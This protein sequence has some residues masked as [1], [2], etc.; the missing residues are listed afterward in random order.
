MNNEFE[1][2]VGEE[3]RDRFF[4]C[5]EEI[6]SSKLFD[7]AHGYQGAKMDAARHFLP[8]RPSILGFLSARS[9][10]LIRLQPN[11]SAKQVV[12]FPE[13]IPPQ[14]ISQ[15]LEEM[16]KMMHLQGESTI[17]IMLPIQREIYYG[18]QPQRDGTTL[19][20]SV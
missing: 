10:N 14:H 15:R 19:K 16:P 8:I 1:S 9:V 7:I 17:V 4:S 6:S 3:T 12:L 13:I 5:A 11:S 2:T 18:R 20:W